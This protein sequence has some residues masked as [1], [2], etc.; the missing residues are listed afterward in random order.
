MKP[1]RR[2]G[3]F[4]FEAKLEHRRLLLELAA[5][6]R[7]CGVRCV[8]LGPGAPALRRIAFPGLKLARRVNGL[9]ALLSLGGDGTL[10]G[11]VAMAAPAAIPVL[12]VNLGQ[13]GYM[14]A[15]GAGSLEAELPALLQGRGRLERRAMLSGRILRRGK[16]PL[17]VAALNDAVLGRPRRGKLAGIEARVDGRPLAKYRAD[18]LII[19]TPTGST[20]YAL[21]AGGP[22]V[23]PQ[24]DALLLVPIAPHTL[25]NRPLVLPGRALLEF[26]PVPG[27][28]LHLSLD[29]AA[30]LPLR[31]GDVLQLRRSPRPAFLILAP[32]HDPWAVLRAKLGWQQPATAE[33]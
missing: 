25:S 24:A 20:A 18:G 23:A 19:S 28:D 33:G 3:L 27:A 10:L 16:A 32:S 22:I 26:R 12:G 21:A 2:A 29:G 8:G 4:A 15:V 6:L 5:L 1:I 9:H 17:P 13:L 31:P 11:A 14:T 7:R 30:P